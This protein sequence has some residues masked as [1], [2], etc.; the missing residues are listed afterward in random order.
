MAKYPSIVPIPGTFNPKHIGE[1]INALKIIHSSADM[2]ELENGFAEIK[3]EGTRT[4]EALF[5][6]HDIGAILG[7][8]SKEIQG[9]TPLPLNKN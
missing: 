3:V 1:N 8:S 7:E 9:K 4:T 6:N 5:A 2:E